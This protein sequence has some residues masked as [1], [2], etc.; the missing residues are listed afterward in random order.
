MK[1]KKAN[2]EPRVYMAVTVLLMLL[3][4]SC[5]LA[6]GL[7]SNFESPAPPRSATQTLSHPVRSGQNGQNGALRAHITRWTA[8]FARSG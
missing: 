2:S 4:I 8:Y 6:L 3:S 7:R 5:M 1:T